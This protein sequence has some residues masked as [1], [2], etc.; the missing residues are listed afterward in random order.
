[1]RLTLLLLCF[2]SLSVYAQT[3]CKNNV[4]TDPRNPTNDD[5]DPSDSLQERLLNRFDWLN[6]DSVTGEKKP[7]QLNNMHSQAYDTVASIINIAELE[8]EYYDYIRDAVSMSIAN[9][10]ELM[11]INTGFWPNMTPIGYVSIF[12]DPRI[13]LYN[14]Y[15]ETIRVFFNVFRETESEFIGNSY[16]V[17][18]YFGNGRRSGLLRENSGEDMTL[19]EVTTVQDVRAICVF[20]KKWQGWGSADFKVSYDPCTCQ[21]P[22][23]IKFWFG[24][25]VNSK[26]QVYNIDGNQTWS[27]L[28]DQSEKLQITDYLHSFGYVGKSESKRKV[29]GAHISNKSVLSLLADLHKKLLIKNIG[30]IEQGVTSKNSQKEVAL[31]RFIREYVVLSLSDPNVTIT[32]IVASLQNLAL[33]EDLANDK[34]VELYGSFEQNE[35][36]WFKVVDNEFDIVLRNSSQEL[37][38][39]VEMMTFLFKEIASELTSSLNLHQFYMNDLKS[40]YIK[41]S[42]SY[43]DLT[44]STGIN[45]GG[46][47]TNPSVIN[48]P[49]KY[50]NHEY[51]S[52][53][54]KVIPIYNDV[55]GSFALLRQPKIKVVRKVIYESDSVIQSTTNNTISAVGGT[56]NLNTQRHKEWTNEYQI[57]LGEPLRYAINDVLDIQEYQIKAQIV[58]KAVPKSALNPANSLVNAY[59]DAK[60]SVNTLS[61]EFNEKEYFPVLANNQPYQHYINNP[62]S[63]AQSFYGQSMPQKTLD[64]L[65]FSSPYVDVNA[66]KPFVMSVGVKNEM[67]TYNS[68]KIKKSELNKLDY[69][70]TNGELIFNLNQT[71]IN[72]PPNFDVA[73]L[74]TDYELS[75]ELKL[76]IDFIFETVD[77]QGQLN[78]STKILNYPIKPE[79]VSWMASSFQEDLANST[80]NIT[81]YDKTLVLHETIF[82]GQQVEGCELNNDTYTCGAYQNLLVNG[83]LTTTGN[84]KVNIL[85]GNTLNVLNPSF[86]GVNVTLL[87]SSIYDYSDS[88]PNVSQVY[89]NSYC[90]VLSFGYNS[91]YRALWD[92]DF[93]SSVDNEPTN[94]PASD[95]LTELDVELFPNP[96]E[97]RTYLRVNDQ[98]IGSYQIFISDILGR[99]L[100]MKFD[101]ISDELYLINFSD[102]PAGIYLIII[103]GQNYAVTKKLVLQK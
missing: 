21:N 27:D 34:Y 13:I 81:K 77:D 39:D 86:I 103:N 43:P 83:S 46:F 99:Q 61:Q 51:G 8:G 18:A 48:S 67:I 101:I 98:E 63:S 84:Y 16:W 88:M 25:I 11:Q 68:Q 29:I 2:F 79:N 22:F 36:D 60:G 96:T 74:G 49:G 91:F 56:I 14:K 65:Y 41:T 54:D 71:G 69:E 78:K 30:L 3:D 45:Y 7:Y 92:E 87:D 80:K 97:G 38:L 5:L 23:F 20:P 32:E 95:S 58:V 26:D 75:F 47:F 40:E 73:D 17:D 57:K 53:I 31:M 10:W 12:R 19:D 93:L 44:Y 4:S 52:N 85:K 62:F 37:T 100:P 33:N 76:I 55:L 50:K 42:V 89:I 66:F 59:H 15:S 72:L 94:E 6:I 35:L 64:T 70:E 1:M 90:D 82:N 9:G 28:Y 102:Y 24:S